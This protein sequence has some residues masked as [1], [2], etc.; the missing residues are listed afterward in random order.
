MSRHSANIPT[1]PVAPPRPHA[2][3]QHPDALQAQLAT[4]E[5][6]FP[7]C[8]H[9][10]YPAFPGKPLDLWAP[11]LLNLPKPDRLVDRPYG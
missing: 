10:L 7:P 9:R 6:H 11:L 2:G 8:R 4:R 1:F 5:S 3:A